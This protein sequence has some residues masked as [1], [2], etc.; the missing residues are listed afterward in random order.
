MSGFKNL[1]VWQKSY[2][3]TLEIYRLSKN[4]PQD[5]RFGITSQIRRAA[6]SVPAN[7]SEGYERNYRKEYLQFLHVAKGSLGEIETFLMLSNDLGYLTIDDYNK[8]ELQRAEIG[9]MLKGLISSLSKTL[10]P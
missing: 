7:I 3:L 9:K 1:G 2:D 8:L 10:A 5:E 6:Y 4:F